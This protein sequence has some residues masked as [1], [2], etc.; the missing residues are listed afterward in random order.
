MSIG[1]SSFRQVSFQDALWN[2]NSERNLKDSV[3]H[4]FE[5]RMHS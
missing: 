4:Y 1:L 2:I 5:V 3:V